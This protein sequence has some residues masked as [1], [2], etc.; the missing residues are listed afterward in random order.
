MSE[1]TRGLLDA[2]N[3]FDLYTRNPDDFLGLEGVV[4]VISV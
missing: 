3:G 4:T 2:A 1:P